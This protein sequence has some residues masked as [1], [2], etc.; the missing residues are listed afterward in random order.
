M[1]VDAAARGPHVQTSFCKGKQDTVDFPA[2]QRLPALPSFFLPNLTYNPSA[3][4]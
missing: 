1:R 3:W 4:A 2:G